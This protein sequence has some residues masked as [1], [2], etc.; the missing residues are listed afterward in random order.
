MAKDLESYKVLVD[1]LA[2]YLGENTEV[3]LHDLSDCQSSIV[4]IRNGDISGRELGAPVTD[5]GLKLIKNEAYKEAPYRVNYR[6]MSPRGNIIRSATYF[7]KDDDGELIGL[8]CLNMDCQKFAEARDILE[9]L[10]TVEPLRKDEE[11]EEN[12]NIN[13]K[14]LVIN[15]MSRVL[16]SNHGD[17]RK[18]GKQEKIEVVERLQGL[19]TFM[20]KGTIWHVA[21][22]LGVSVPTVYRYLATIKKENE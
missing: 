9:S 15:N 12:F 2:D 3:V 6:G 11:T 1:F 21:D 14:E 13:V 7:I 10:I 8:L 20:V 22:M 18:M 17:L 19:G 5:Y 4:A 16:P